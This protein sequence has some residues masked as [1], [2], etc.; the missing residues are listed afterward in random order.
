M[1]QIRIIKKLLVR[2]LVCFRNEETVVVKIY[3]SL[4]TCIISQEMLFQSV[5]MF[6]EKFIWLHFG[7][8]ET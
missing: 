8:K 1:P 2:N 5:I 3:L 4:S 6:Q 7:I